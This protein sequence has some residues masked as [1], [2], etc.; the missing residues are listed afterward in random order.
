VLGFSKEVLVGKEIGRE[1]RKPGSAVRPPHKSFSCTQP[2][3]RQAVEI[4]A[5]NKG[6]N[7]FQSIEAGT[8]NFQSGHSRRGE[9]DG[10]V[11]RD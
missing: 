3:V 4:R 9:K 7:G 2:L 11:S 10:A 5:P 8:L 1:L 6:H